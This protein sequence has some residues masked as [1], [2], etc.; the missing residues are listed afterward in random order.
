MLYEVITIKMVG[1]LMAVA[2]IAIPTT[3]AKIN[4]QNLSQM[5]LFSLIF[6]ISATL[7]GLYWSLYHSISSGGAIIVSNCLWLLPCYLY[8]SVKGGAHG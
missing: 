3:C 8:K 4:S 5:I 1:A 6:A 2:L 7:L